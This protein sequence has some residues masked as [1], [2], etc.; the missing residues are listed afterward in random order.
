MIQ[1]GVDLF[2]SEIFLLKYQFAG[3]GKG[4]L[5]ELKRWISYKTIFAATVLLINY[6]EGAL[7][8]DF[9]KCTKTLGLCEYVDE[10]CIDM[11]D[12]WNEK[13]NG[14]KRIRHNV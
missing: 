11:D 6:T 4:F 3:I 12:Q 8:I 9:M 14:S 10:H 2:I 7:G 1:V 5:C 13:K